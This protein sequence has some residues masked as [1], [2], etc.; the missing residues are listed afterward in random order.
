MSR[1]SRPRA[2][3]QRPDRPA[4]RRRARIVWGCFPRFDGD[5]VFCALLDDAAAGDERGI[6][7]IELVDAVRHEQSYD[8]NTAVLVHA[9]LDRD[10]GAIEITDC[11]PRFVQHGRVFHPMTLRPQDPARSRAARGSWSACGPR[12]ATARCSPTATVGSNH[13]RYVGPDL[14]LRLTTDASLTAII[15]ERPF[16]LDREMT[17]LLGPDETLPTAVAEVG[18]RFI[19][20]TRAYW[21]D[22]VRRLAIP[23]EW[24]AAVIRAAITLQ[25]NAFD[26]TG[27]IVAAMTTSIPEAPD[28][29]RN[30]DYR[31][32]WLRDGY[33]VVDALN[34][35]GATDTMER[36]LGYIVNIAA[37]SRRRAAAA[38]L[39]DQR[40]RGPG[41]GGRRQPARATA[42]WGRCASAT[43]PT[44]RC[45][46]TSTAR[47]SSP[48][49]TSSS[50]SG[51]RSAATR[52]CSSASKPLGRRAVAVFDQPDAGLWELR[53]R[54]CACTRSPASC[55]GPPATGWRASRAAS[56]LRGR[57]ATLAHRCATASS[58]SSTSA[59]GASG[60]G[61]FVAA[62]DGDALDA[63]L[64]LLADLGFV[65][66]D[67][68]RFAA[69]VERDR[70]AT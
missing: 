29:G 59:A 41:R 50:T 36:Y 21:R 51:W 70:A 66:P 19:E 44:G 42:A 40:R 24:Q 65:A 46:T 26:D 45:S 20:E 38:R 55:A 12:S 58:A 23:F 7:A 5:P 2:G 60:A 33:F 61:S 3:R 68:P 63:S 34:R 14:T 37:G 9:P 27:A 43:T 6:F 22:W 47:R 69:T 28:S 17:L 53:G 54:A 62:V 64:L 52:R 31:Y 48:R 10:G 16:F 1:E 35:L 18:R 67:D 4:G 32:C 30:W 56:G 25:Q 13:I 39:P 57:A 11:V 49:R 8:P 15:E